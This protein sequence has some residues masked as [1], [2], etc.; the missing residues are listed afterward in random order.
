MEMKEERDK[1]RRVWRPTL[2]DVE[3]ISQ[4]LAAKNRGVGSRAVCHRLNQD[5]RK[6]Y[7]LAKRHGFL[8]V[9]GT[10]YRKE[11]KGSPLINT[12]RQLCDAQGICF[13]R[14]EKHG[15]AGASLSLDT[16]VVD[17]SP[18]RVTDDSAIVDQ[19]HA[20][21]ERMDCDSEKAREQLKFPKVD[22]DLLETQPIWA[23]QEREV[24]VSCSS[25]EKAKELATEMVKAL[26]IPYGK[27]INQKKKKRKRKRE[28][29]TRTCYTSYNDNEVNLF[30]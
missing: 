5:E 9:K 16:V 10:G 22:Q 7:D 21:A 23:I 15:A 3:R 30:F 27:D 1:Q 25:R 19:V 28:K 2:E 6:V 17:L 12:F 29:E 11:R 13:V 26:G 8:A 20:L 14:L 24:R 4:G 18:L